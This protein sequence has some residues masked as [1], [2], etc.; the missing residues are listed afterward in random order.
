VILLDAS[1][2]LALVNDEAG[3]DTVEEH[4]GEASLMS[5]NL[6][7]V[8]GILVKAGMTPIAAGIALAPLALPVAPFTEEMAWLS[9]TLRPRLPRGLGIADRACLAAASVLGASVL[10]ADTLWGQAA[11]TFGVDVTIIR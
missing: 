5:V 10:T 4:L 1:A 6:E 7:E 9:G 2:L 11:T 3:S 8:V